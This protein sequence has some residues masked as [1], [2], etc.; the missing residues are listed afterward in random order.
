[1]YSYHLFLTSASLK[2]LLFLSFIILIF[3]W[4]APLVSPAFLKRYLV[5]HILLFS[6]I[7]LHCL[8]KKAAL[9]LLPILWKSAF[10]WVYLSLSLCLLLLFS[11]IY[12]RPPQTTI[13]P[14]CISFSS[15]CFWLPPSVQYY[16]PLS[17]VL[18]ALCL[19]LIKRGPLEKEMAN[20]FSILA[21]KNPWTVEKVKIYDNRR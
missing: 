2:S 3:A 12:V 17:I 21:S 19:P 10:S 20:H 5:F 7:S 15:G 16:D 1:M 18:Q 8:L 4:N 11:A 9:P 6:S 14:F 13:L